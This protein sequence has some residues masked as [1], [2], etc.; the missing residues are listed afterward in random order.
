MLFNPECFALATSDQD[1]ALHVQFTPTGH[2]LMVMIAGWDAQEIP[3]DLR[4]VWEYND[5]EMLVDMHSIELV[6][7]SVY[8]PGARVTLTFPASGRGMGL[9]E[10][11]DGG[12]M[13]L[14]RMPVQVL[15][16]LLKHDIKSYLGHS[17]RAFASAASVFYEEFYDFED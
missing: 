6:G 7:A 13:M 10:D 15:D 4:L 16:L 8:H 14:G 11:E 1:E 2:K 12:G 9:S 17:T 3:R 5:A